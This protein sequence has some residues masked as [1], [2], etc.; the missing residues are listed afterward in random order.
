MAHKVTTEEAINNLKGR[1]SNLQITVSRIKRIGV[2]DQEGINLF[3]DQVKEYKEIAANSKD[4]ALDLNRVDSK[5]FTLPS[6]IQ[7][8][9]AKIFR[10]QE[11]AFQV[12]LDLLLKNSEASEHYGPEMSEL[13]AR[14]AE[15]SKLDRR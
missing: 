5:G 15:L 9:Q 11:Y 6:D 1:L 8:A 12:V 7:E 10:G 13:E 14:I 3:I 4:D 2:R